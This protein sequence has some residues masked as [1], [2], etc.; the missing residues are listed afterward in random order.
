VGTQLSRL[1]LRLL[2]LLAST[3]L[4]YIGIHLIHEVT[5]RFTV[6]SLITFDRGYAEYFMYAKESWLLLLLALFT[7]RRF[8]PVY[9]AWG[10]VCL[11]FFVDD[12]FTIRERLSEWMVEPLNLQ[13][14]MG[15]R[16]RDLGELIVIG[17]AA[18]VLV[19]AV[20]YTHR[21]SD[22]VG[23]RFSTGMFV[24]V[25]VFAAFG[26]LGD[27]IH[28]LASDTEAG[29]IIAGTIE[30]GGEMLAMSAIVA[31]VFRHDPREGEGDDE[32]LARRRRPKKG[33]GAPEAPRRPR[34]GDA[35][36]AAY[37]RSFSCPARS[38]HGPDDGRGM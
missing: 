9:L 22:A 23:R 6:L 36:D 32:G 35:T 3:D 33:V 38:I 34:Y 16:A 18:L 14:A 4:V 20:V 24:L 30:D 21:R 31:F 26:V 12:C 13:P 8:R 28:Q 10:L 25:A 11:Y 7:I 27:M 19:P 29:D 1:D 17:A 15:L 2:L 5:G 37:R